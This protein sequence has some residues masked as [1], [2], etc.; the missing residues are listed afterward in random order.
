MAPVAIVGGREDP[1]EVS[2]NRYT[3]R[4]STS[5]V[6]ERAERLRQFFSVAPMKRTFGM[7]LTYDND[8]HARFEMPYLM[9]LCHAMKDTHGGAIATLE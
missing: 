3:A 1:P 6:S 9:D 7:E 5:I 8:G 2:R 4:M